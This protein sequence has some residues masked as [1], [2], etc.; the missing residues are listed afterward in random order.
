MS[1]YYRDI[2]VNG[3]VNEIFNQAYQWLTAQGFVY[4]QRGNEMVFQKGVGFL[5]APR[6]IK[7]SFSGNIIRVEAWI[8]MFTFFGESDCS[9]GIYW[10]IVP[11]KMLLKVVRNLE[12][13]LMQY[14][15]SAPIQQPNYYQ[16]QNY[17]YQQNGQYQ[18]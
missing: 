10:G 15:G 6:I 16:Q 2:Q 14:S 11:K 8:V 18:N 3:D 12:Q 17:T 7:L 5:M 1:R 4:K 13:A 9:R